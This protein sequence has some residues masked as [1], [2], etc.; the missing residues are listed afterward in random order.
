MV[1]NRHMKRVDEVNGKM[2]LEKYNRLKE[3]FTPAAN[4]EKVIDSF[5]MHEIYMGYKRYK[6]ERGGRSRMDKSLVSAQLHGLLFRLHQPP[7]NEADDTILRNSF[8][9]ACTK[10][11]P[12]NPLFITASAL[13][14]AL[15]KDRAENLRT[16]MPFMKR[17]KRAFN[18][19]DD[20]SWHKKRDLLEARINKYQPTTQHASPASPMTAAI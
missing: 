7:N 12:L 4:P 19:A 14:A 2:N 16:D 5:H 20:Y 10:G 8:R 11:R 3:F 1:I 6:Y 17:I 15:S 9:Y 18:L 13:A